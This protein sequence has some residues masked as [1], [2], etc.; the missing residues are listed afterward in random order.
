M[1]Y[2]LTEQIVV[3]QKQLEILSETFIAITESTTEQQNEILH[4]SIENKDEE[5]ERISGELEEKTETIASKEEEIL[6]LQLAI[7][8]KDA[9]IAQLQ[10]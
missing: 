6:T 8:T 2:K 4:Q 7:T 10:R 3:Q 5:L 9:T 1:L